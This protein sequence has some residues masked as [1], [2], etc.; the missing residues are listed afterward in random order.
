MTAI[1]MTAVDFWVDTAHASHI[2]AFDKHTVEEVLTQVVELVAEDSSHDSDGVIS[3]F[4]HYS[5]EHF[6]EPPDT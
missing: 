1:T 4:S 3:F 5:V 6:G 2:G